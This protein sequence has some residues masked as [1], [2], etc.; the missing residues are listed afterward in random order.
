MTCIRILI[1]IYRIEAVA[2]STVPET[3]RM[4][5]AKYK[6]LGYLLRLADE[7][8]VCVLDVT[9]VLCSTLQ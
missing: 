3:R 2:H 5:T 6:Y 7:F 4:A 1:E 9:E 8:S